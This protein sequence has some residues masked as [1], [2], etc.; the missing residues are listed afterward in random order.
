MEQDEYGQNITAPPPSSY[1]QY[2][3]ASPPPSSYDQ[4]VTASPQ[5]PSSY[6]QYTMEDEQNRQMRTHDTDDR[7]Q[8]VDDV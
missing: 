5:P 6:D 2:V 7:A 3:T 8:L 4:Y 1:D